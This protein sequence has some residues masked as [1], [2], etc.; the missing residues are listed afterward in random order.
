MDNQLAVQLSAPLA[1][2]VG[3]LICFA[4][5]RLVKLTLALIGFIAGASGGWAV[6]LA[7]FPNNTTIALICALLA[8]VILAI[9]CV[10]LFFLGVFILG[11]SAGAVV[12]AAVFR[13]TGFPVQALLIL[14]VALVFGVIA[15]VLQKLMIILSTAFS[16]SYLATA[17]LAHFLA[18]VQQVHPL[19]FKPYSGNA[20]ETWGYVIL[21]IWLLLGLIGA[22][23]QYVVG[24]RE[25]AAA[26]QE[27]A[28]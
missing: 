4:G 18:G 22:R 10:W 19:W 11:A 24:S 28:A 23:F 25:K 12:A 17:A 1:A 3:L 7:L 26:R 14:V 27:A 6:G 16:G 9:L 13:A 8:G 5:Y 20:S 15:L 21:A 2:V